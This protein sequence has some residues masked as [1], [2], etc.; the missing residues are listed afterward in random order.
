MDIFRYSKKRD[1]QVLVGVWLPPHI[2]DYL[3]L[4]AMAHNESKS[5]IMKR[6]LQDWFDTTSR[7]TPM[8]EV[9][10]E[11][12]AVVRIQYNKEKLEKSFSPVDFR[13]ELKVRLEKQKIDLSL[14]QAI[15]EGAK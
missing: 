10:D 11:L 1:K 6:L 14:I 9:I 8:E 3:T 15:M 7:S 12:K 13:R 2:R 4:Y 5:A